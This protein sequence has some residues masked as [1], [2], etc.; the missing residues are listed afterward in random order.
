M[1]EGRWGRHWTLALRR[2]RSRVLPSARKTTSRFCTDD[3]TVALRGDDE[4]MDGSNAE[5]QA[6]L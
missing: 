1:R 3:Y 2:S 4:L 6:V 5:D